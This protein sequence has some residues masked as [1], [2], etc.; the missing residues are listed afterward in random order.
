M[1]KTTFLH[2]LAGYV[3]PQEGS[4]TYE[5]TGT[6]SYML[7]MPSLIGVLT[8][9]ENVMLSGLIEHMPDYDK[10]Y[11]LLER[12]GLRHRAQE[13][14]AQLSGGEQQR[15]ACIQTLY[16]TASV[17]LAD[18]PTAH[19]DRD[20]ARI[21]IELLREK[22]EQ[23]GATVVVATHDPLVVMHAHTVLSWGS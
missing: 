18:E 8:V 5:A 10:A 12:V 21:I 20:N 19:L 22:S 1:G 17:V 4:I 3:Q 2:M 15:I 16:R 13:Y 6:I 9:C 14:P 23:E 11:T 7:Q